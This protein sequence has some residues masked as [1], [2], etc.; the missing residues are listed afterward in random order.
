MG[1][2]MCIRDSREGEA[3]NVITLGELTSDHADMLTLVLI[4]NSQTRLTKRGE[5]DWVY[6]PRGYAA[7]IAK[8]A[9]SV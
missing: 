1:S 6:T 8:T 7:K 3:I 9:E 2:E 5:R 4:G